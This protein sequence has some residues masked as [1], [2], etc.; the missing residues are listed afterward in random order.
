VAE[1]MTRKLEATQL[2]DGEITAKLDIDVHDMDLA[3]HKDA[4]NPQ[5]IDTAVTA[6]RTVMY[7]YD[8]RSWLQRAT[9]IFLFFC[10]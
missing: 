5:C 10:T 8:E 4:H 6:V 7:N 3:A 9:L 1:E 2:R